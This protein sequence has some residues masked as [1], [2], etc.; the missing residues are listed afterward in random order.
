MQ[1]NSS[2]KFFVMRSAL[3]L[4]A[5]SLFA[6]VAVGQQAY[7]GKY[8]VYAGYVY[9]NSSLID[10]S[11]HGYHLQVGMNPRR[12]L[13]MG[14][15]FSHSTGDTYLTPEMLLPSLQQKLGAQLKQLAAAG[16][17]PSGYTLAVKT[18]SV[19]DSFAAGPQLMYRR[20]SFVSPFIR[21][22]I[23]AIHEVATPK[24]SDP[25]AAAIVKQLSPSGEKQDWR[26]F[27][28]VGGGFDINASK[29]LGFRVQ[30]DFVWDYLY[31]DL[32][33]SGRH[34]VRFSVGPTIHLGPNV[35]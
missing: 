8:D 14:F 13:A 2:I 19:T 7:V 11:E 35:E 6:S 21:P 25:I 22:S 10:L 30:A 18:G 23:G 12:W 1:R 3:V 28:G 29:H 24:A 9:F 31:N 26:P 27:Y 5:I 34:T 20:W 32:L 33:R 15:D 16:M 4:L 17:L